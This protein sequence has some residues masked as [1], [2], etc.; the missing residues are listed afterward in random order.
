M[1]RSRGSDPHVS[2]KTKTLPLSRQARPIPKD[3]TWIGHRTWILTAQFE[4]QEESHIYK[5]DTKEL[6]P[7]LL[8]MHVVKDKLEFTHHQ[9]LG[10][11]I[12]TWLTAW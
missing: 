12:F 3:R 10:K 9:A 4:C 7:S 6:T 8:I 5:V 2:A 11:G 1:R